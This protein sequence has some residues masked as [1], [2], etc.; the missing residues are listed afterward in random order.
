MISTRG[1]YALRFLIDLTERQGEGYI[2]LKEISQ[3]KNV[4]L[5]YLE[6]IVSLLSKGDVIISQRGKDGGYKLSRPAGEI[7][8]GAVL[9]LTE[10]KLAPVSCLEC[11]E[12]RCE[13]AD[14]CLTL[15]MWEKLD[16]LIEDYLSSVTIQDIVDGN[17]KEK[18]DK[19][20]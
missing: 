11:E 1:R 5:K 17:I 12:N 3:R 2:P 4:S 10:G 16:G 8:V 14:A 7:T 20:G 15:P 13:R 19:N 18:S 6:S 9:R